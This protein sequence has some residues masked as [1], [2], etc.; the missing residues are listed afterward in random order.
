MMFRYLIW[1]IKR[2]FKNSYAILLIIFL[3]VVIFTLK[4]L[5]SSQNSSKFDA[6][7]LED[8]KNDDKFNAKFLDDVIKDSRDNID[9]VIK[10][11]RDNIAII[12]KNIDDIDLNKNITFYEVKKNEE[13][14]SFTNDFQPENYKPCYNVHIFYYPWYGNPAVDGDFVHW[15]HKYLPHWSPEVAKMYPNGKHVPPLDIGSNFYPELG[16]YSSADIKVID[17]HMQQILMGNIGVLAVSYYPPGLYDDN[18]KDWQFLLPKIFNVAAKY[19][20]KV[21]FHIEPYKDRSEVTLK[22]DIEHI[23]RVYGSHPAFYKHKH[24]GVLRPLLYVYD[25]YHTKPEN[26]KQLLGTNSTLSIRDTAN[27]CFVI[28][29]L[30]GQNHKQDIISSG[31]DG[32]YT[33][34]A[35][36]GFTYGSSRYNWKSL[37][38]FADENDLLYIPS[39][40]PGYI[41]TRV[42]PW[43]AENTRKRLK[44]KYYIDSWNAALNVKP[45]LISITSFNE[46][47]EGTQIEKAIPKE[48]T[49]FKYLDYSPSPPDFYL[50]LTNKY[51]QT[52]SKCSI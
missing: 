27:D 14:L 36:N 34:F 1:M 12:S 48:T 38:S 33:Y 20:L 26:W 17:N 37:K 47:H 29:L 28:G 22:Q 7:F 31:F 41:D 42:R 4:H 11:S 40:G 39:I 13:V 2:F 23:L 44:G 18:G 35:A 46:W 52:F 50:S 16:A 9:D 32:F 6:N 51:V 8:V 21:T 19:K 30:V 25:S 3:V 45:D 15:N 10:D 43:N 49:N 24:K 5:Y